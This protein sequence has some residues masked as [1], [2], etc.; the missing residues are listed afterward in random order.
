MLT[1]TIE[2]YRLNMISNEYGETMVVITIDFKVCQS[3]KGGGGGSYFPLPW[4][5]S[6]I[7]VCI[8]RNMNCYLFLYKIIIEDLPSNPVYTNEWQDIRTDSAICKTSKL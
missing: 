5:C 4:V 3:R 2:S 1:S 6:C 7:C 8:Q